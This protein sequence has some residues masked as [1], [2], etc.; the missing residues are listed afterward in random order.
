MCSRGVRAPLLLKIS[1]VHVDTS[2]GIRATC[3]VC[4][5]GGIASYARRMNSCEIFAVVFVAL[6]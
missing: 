1:I 2:I 5:T 3:C 6:L 4:V